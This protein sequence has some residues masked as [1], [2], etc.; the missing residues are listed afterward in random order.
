MSNDEDSDR[1]WNE[2][3]WERF[4]KQSE[5]RADRF[6]ELL[7]TLADH[8]DAEAIIAREMGWDTP[9]G[10]D[11]ENGETVESWKDEEPDD[12][13]ESIAEEDEDADEADED[14]FSLFDED[15]EDEGEDDE[16]EED[17]DDDLARFAS[18]RRRSRNAQPGYK[19]AFAYGVAVHEALKPFTPE[20]EGDEPPDEDDDLFEAVSN[21]FIIAA[22]LAG[23]HGMGYDEDVLC[24]NIVCC[25]R[26]L[27][28]ARKS[29]AALERLAA[30]TVVPADVVRPLIPE[31]QEVVRIIEAHIAD[32][33]SRV[34]WA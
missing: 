17:E 12:S 33:R 29:C 8:P 6:G 14:P 25:R 15:D 23:A 1:P 30:G 26:A 22:K 18:E 34:W 4:L 20:S 7:E 13:G 32:L 3:Q 5:A 11:D 19:R 2:E 28:A 24:G 27:D 31:A 9:E 21:G 10:A 16:G